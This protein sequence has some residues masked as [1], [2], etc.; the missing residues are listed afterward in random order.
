[1]RGYLCKK[2]RHSKSSKGETKRSIEEIT[3][4]TVN[5]RSIVN[6]TSCLEQLLLDQEPHI[7][8]I[9]ETWLTPDIFNDE[10][11]PPDYAVIRKD[12]PTRGGGVALLIS[13]SIPFVALPDVLGAEAVFCKIICDGINI[14]TGCVYRSPSSGN[15]SIIAVQEF[16][17]S[18]AHNSRLVVMG[19]FN[20][21]DIDWNTMQYT[22]HSSE[23]LIDLILN[24]G[25]QQMVLEPTRITEET[26]TI[27]DLILISGQFPPNDAVVNV[28]PGISDHHIPICKLKLGFSITSRSTV[29]TVR[30]FHKAD[31]ASILAYLAHEFDKFST[32]AVNPLTDVNRIWSSFKA[33]VT[34]CITNFIPLKAK[35]Q[36]KH[37]PWVTRE[38]LQAKRKVK[39]LRYVIKKKAKIQCACLTWQVLWQTSRE[40]QNL[41]KNIIS[42]PHYQTTLRATLIDS[43]NTF[44][45]AQEQLHL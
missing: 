18:Y 35:R 43:G 42:P 41:L 34:F 16:L 44:G 25:L 45:L 15:D 39:R 20:L 13:K 21:P 29:T 32:L 23:T 1:M 31:D 12:R 22:S 6:K 24:F 10:I 4:L 19:D 36:R 28:V 17:Q 2:R 11:A 9:T 30:N 37:N 5:A 3:I 26:K 8:A 40:R 7:V 27:L 33:I 14:V 38:V